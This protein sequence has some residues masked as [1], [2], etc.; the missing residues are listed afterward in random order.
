MVMWGSFLSGTS[1]QPSETKL[2]IYIYRDQL[3]QFNF[4]ESTQREYCKTKGEVD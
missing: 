1:K 2:Y 4:W 3:L